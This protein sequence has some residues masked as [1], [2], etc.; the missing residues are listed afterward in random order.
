[1]DIISG[2]RRSG[3][4]TRLLEWL[5]EGHMNG[6]CR[7]LLVINKLEVLRLN[8]ILRELWETCGE[9]EYINR[10]ANY[11]VAYQDFRDFVPQRLPYTEIA[12]DNMDMVLAQMLNTIN[13]VSVG[14]V[15]AEVEDETY[16]A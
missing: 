1:M 11:I 14:S 12:V 7:L 13:V 8:R 6:D 4:T 2:P 15:E 10:A 5:L 16:S 9:P 3:R